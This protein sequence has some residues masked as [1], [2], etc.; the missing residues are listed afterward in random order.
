MDLSASDAGS[1]SSS[2][3]LAAAAAALIDGDE[4]ADVGASPDPY[5]NR[6]PPRPESELLVVLYHV[7]QA[8]WCM[9]SRGMAH[10]DIKPANILFTTVP[11]T[12]AQ[13]GFERLAGGGLG[14]KQVTVCV[15][16]W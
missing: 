3:A 5:H 14:P 13:S 2:D 11:D 12:A 1:G 15:L 9:H 7:A 6:F 8:L 16:G 10:M 4:E